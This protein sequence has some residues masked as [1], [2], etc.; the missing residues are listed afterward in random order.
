MMQSGD[1]KTS[2]RRPNRGSG[3]GDGGGSGNGMDSGVGMGVGEGPA[4]T[5][6]FA[7]SPGTISDA[8]HKVR[9]YTS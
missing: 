8:T 1:V 9:D 2:G 5:D 3:N 6:G 7:V 4:G